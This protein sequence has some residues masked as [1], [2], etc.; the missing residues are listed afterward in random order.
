MPYKLIRLFKNVLK[1]FIGSRNVERLA[2]MR[3]RKQLQYICKEQSFSITGKLDVL[4]FCEQPSHWQNIQLVVDSILERNLSLSI[5]LATTY[6]NASYPNANYPSSVPIV[7]GVNVGMLR[8]FNAQIIYTPFVGLGQEWRPL[9]SR[10]IHSLVSMTGLDGVYSEYS[11]DCCDYIICAGPHQVDS[12]QKWSRGRS[13]LS[14]KTVIPAGY[15]KLDLVLSTQQYRKHQHQNNGSQRA[16][17]YAPTHVGSINESLASLRLYGEGIVSALMNAGYKVTFR[18]HPVSC[19]DDDKKLVDRIVETH[20]NK[21]NFTFDRSKNYIDTYSKTDLMVTDLSGTGFT[22]S[23]S[24]CRP[25]I[26]F[27]PNEEAERGLS[28]IQF[29]SREHIGAVIR[30]ID[31]L[32]EKV[33]ELCQNDMSAEII[34]FRG[35]TVYNIAHS[36]PYIVD[37]IDDIIAGCERPEWVC[38]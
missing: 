2:L 27:A 25:S 30:S 17:V 26:F 5:G 19:H 23:F 36:S 1:F 37:C 8:F 11:F 20:Q 29:E 38:L 9:G 7:H 31:K 35:E 33:D 21:P 18:P 14:G 3:S 13:E 34:K 4:F 16:V 10:V 12:F 22:Y 6:L 24:F 32:I 28:G 15:P